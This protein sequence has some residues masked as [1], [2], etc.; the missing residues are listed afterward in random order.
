MLLRDTIMLARKR[1][2]HNQWFVP[3]KR[4]R[5]ILN[6]EAV[7]RQIEACEVPHHNRQECVELILANATS[8]FGILVCLRQEALIM[9]FISNGLFDKKLPLGEDEVEGI[10]VHDE[11]FILQPAFTSPVFSRTS[12]ILNLKDEC[13]LPFLEDSK[14]GG[15][16]YGN[17]FH[18]SLDPLHQKLETPAKD[19]SVCLS[20]SLIVPPPC[21]WLAFNC[22][23]HF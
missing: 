10:N 4:L 5:Q 1:T 3:E 19:G 13:I 21:F 23:L 7:S 14:M 6:R 20:L 22:S 11:F 16:G 15:G 9:E 8:L 2:A 17:S 18:V 12:I